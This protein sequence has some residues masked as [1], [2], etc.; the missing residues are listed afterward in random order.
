MVH[1]VYLFIYINYILILN[2]TIF[3]KL[4]KERTDTHFVPFLSKL[5][6]FKMTLDKYIEELKNSKAVKNFTKG[7]QINR[8]KNLNKYLEDGSKN[9]LFNVLYNN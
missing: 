5:K 8:Q 9:N 2:L 1:F 6:I 3:T 4:F 7:T